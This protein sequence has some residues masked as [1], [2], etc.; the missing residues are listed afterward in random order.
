MSWYWIQNQ[1]VNRIQFMKR[2]LDG[3]HLCA[4][5]TV[6]QEIHGGAQLS[7]EVYELILPRRL[8]E[9]MGGEVWI[10]GSS[11]SIPLS[12]QV[13]CFYTN[14]PSAQPNQFILSLIFC[15]VSH[16]QETGIVLLSRRREWGCRW[17]RWR[18]GAEFLFLRSLILCCLRAFFFYKC[19]SQK[20]II[21]L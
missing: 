2:P 4:Q 19:I 17:S 13:T 12:C 1:L 16:S 20:C 10:F 11:C 6:Q 18:K 9:S 5:Y 14:P 21:F 7:V 8:L 15:A 3:V